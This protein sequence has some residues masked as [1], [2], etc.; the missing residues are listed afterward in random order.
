MNRN[1]QATVYGAQIPVS[2]TVAAFTQAMQGTSL[3][4]ALKMA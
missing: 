4:V 2:H 3:S 1:L